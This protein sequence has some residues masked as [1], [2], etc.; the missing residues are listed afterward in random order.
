M[1][2]RQN[3][4]MVCIQRPLGKRKVH[5]FPYRDHQVFFHLPHIVREGESES[6]YVCVCVLAFVRA[7]MSEV[8]ARTHVV[9]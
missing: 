5:L 2:N 1:R 6:E 4:N 9:K 8:F 7:S 3:E